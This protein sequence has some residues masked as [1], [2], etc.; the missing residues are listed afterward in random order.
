MISCK[1]VAQLV[2]SD[3]LEEAGWGERLRVR[4]HHLM[5]RRCRRYAA[6]MR[7]LGEYA[8]K[9]WGDPPQDPVT[10]QRLELAILKGFPGHPKGDPEKP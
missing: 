3:G 7:A 8:R 4:L 2:A 9:R 1:E 6:Q 5:C 10:L